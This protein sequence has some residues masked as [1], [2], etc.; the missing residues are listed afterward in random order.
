MRGS[1]IILVPRTPV[2]YKVR[3]NHIRITGNHDRNSQRNLD[4]IRISKRCPVH[5][6]MY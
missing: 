2:P 4:G 3:T 5:T 1:V 6:L